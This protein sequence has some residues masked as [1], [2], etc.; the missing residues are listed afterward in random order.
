MPVSVA[1]PLPLPARGLP[2]RL[3]T[4]LGVALVALAIG[5]G[6]TLLLTAEVDGPSYEI[7]RGLAPF[8]LL[9]S[10]W[11]GPVG[12]LMLA[13]RR[14][15]AGWVF[16]AVGWGYGVTAAGIAW[17]V[18]GVAHPGL[19]GLAWSPSFLLTGWTTATLL[20]ILVLPW[21][22]SRRAP[23]GW[24]RVGAIA[25]TV[26]V[27]GATVIRLLIQVPGAPPHP[28]TGGGT[29][30]QVAAMADDAL[31]P[32][33]VL[34]ALLGLG[35]LGWR[36]RHARPHER[37]QLTW[38]LGSLVAVALGYLAFE[39]GLTLDGHWFLAGTGLI[40]VAE[41]TLPVVVFVLLR[42]QPSWRLDL[43]ISRTLV[44][45]LLTAILVATYVFAV[46]ALSM[47]TPWQQQSS[48]VVVVAALAL[49]VLP[50]RDWLQRHVER[51]VF[52]S[53]ADPSALLQ[54]VAQALDSADDDSPQLA[55]LVTALQRALR[56]SRVEVS[57]HDRTV[58]VAGREEVDADERALRLGLTSHGR[59]I[60]TL[61]AVAP[62]GE[63][64]D[65]RSM[66][67][68]QQISGLVAVAALL[69]ETNRALELARARVVEVRHEERR[70]L[71]RELHDGLGPALSGTALALAAVPSTSALSP[72][73]AVLLERLVDELSRRA[74]DVRQMARVLLPPVLDEGRLGEALRLLAERS[75]M[76][77]FSV[78]VDAP[79]ADRL[80]GLHQVVVYQVAGEAVRNAARHAQARHCEVRL[81]MPAA[82]GVRLTVSDDGRGL[83]P[84]A[85]PG[86]G[87]AAM[88]ER[89]AELGGSVEV[90]GGADGTRVVMVLP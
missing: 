81:E 3:G 51:M 64:L 48:G 6:T 15:L 53:G 19:P 74:D 55:G 87:I 50:L 46:W 78:T 4:G 10:L 67:L 5:T 82:G 8:D 23:T 14:H 59:Q 38:F 9:M 16:L 42:R 89:A 43:A 85:A 37:R 56:L 58:A 11:Y 22:L 35:Y 66:R 88:R 33:Y 68:L 31:V 62:R 61:T 60:G 86:V 25:G 30:S 54:R 44:G 17:T 65:P 2:E 1:A 75:S 45:T 41:L 40:F 52:G 29:P 57:L 90:E 21:L 80:D 70:L 47:V 77:R 7:R 28:I 32:C 27:A 84:D 24:L 49:A 76:P 79:H 73:D 72:D 71:R 39:V 13:R 83:D 63:R 26:V 34:L 18:L 20:T 69:D 36:L 12:A